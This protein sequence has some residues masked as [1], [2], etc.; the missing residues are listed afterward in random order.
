MCV[1][2]PYASSCCLC[3]HI[4]TK[5]IVHYSVYYMR[6]R[7]KRRATLTHARYTRCCSANVAASLVT[8]F[9]I[10]VYLPLRRRRFRIPRRSSTCAQ[11]VV[12]NHYT[13]AHK[14]AVTKREKISNK[15]KCTTSFIQISCGCAASCCRMHTHTPTH[16]HNTTNSSASQADDVRHDFIL[17][18]THESCA[19]CGWRTTDGMF[20][21]D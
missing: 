1:C 3:A 13:T 4:C 19:R 11:I 15:R 5:N 21:C 8:A 14:Q 9:L 12:L 6:A 7:R 10:F 20:R 2:G 17:I 18:R 16:T